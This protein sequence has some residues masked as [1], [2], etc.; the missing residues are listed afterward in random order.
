MIAVLMNS[1][2]GLN[3]IELF[4][5]LGFTYLSLYSARYIPLFAIIVG[6]IIIKR[7]D[8]MLRESNNRVILFL[9]GKSQSYA[10]IEEKTRG[11][12]W[13]ALALGL[14]VL[15]AISGGIKHS[16]NPGKK[17]VAA[18]EFLQQEHIPG[19]M[20]NNDEFGDYIIYASYPEY[21]VFI[22]GRSDMYG[23]DHMKEY[24][25]VISLEK[26]WGN[27][28]EAHEIQW[29]FY[30]ADSLLS[31]YLLERQDWHLLYADKVAHIY[32]RAIQEYEYLINKYQDVQPVHESYL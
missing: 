7:F 25:K 1:K 22:D 4:L 14:V 8:L 21:R 26:G 3:L 9:N 12:L 13:P 24:R 28:L 18:V 23:V 16:F 6:P 29:I 2:S 19:N 20:F 15:L 17:P 31:R 10:E 11:H 27:V 32:V 30:N 5:V